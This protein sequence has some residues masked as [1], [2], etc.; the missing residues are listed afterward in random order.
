MSRQRHD[1]DA[2]LASCSPD[3]HHRFGGDHA[4]GGER[5]DRKALRLW[6][7]RLGRLCPDMRLTVEEV[8]VKGLPHRTTIILR[9]TNEATRPDGSPYHNRGVHLIRMRWGRVTAIDANEDSQAVV[10]LLD[11]LAANGVAE[12]AAPPITS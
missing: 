1:Y 10:E 12:A 4:L 8:W 9:W 11:Q 6:F 7:G 2:V 5:H 3:V